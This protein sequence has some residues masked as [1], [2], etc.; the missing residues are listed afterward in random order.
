MECLTL[1]K[2]TTMRIQTDRQFSIFREFGE[3]FRHEERHQLLSKIVNQHSQGL[4]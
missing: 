2:T 1:Q 4:I 3:V